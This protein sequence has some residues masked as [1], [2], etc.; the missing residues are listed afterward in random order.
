M[1]YRDPNEALRAENESLQQQIKDA[2]EELDG[3]RARVGASAEGDGERQRLAL[4]M[5]CLGGV[6]LML[7]FLL[8]TAMCEHRF[9]PRYHHAPASMAVRYDA[10]PS[11]ASAVNVP[12]P[13]VAH[14]CQGRTAPSP[15]FE[16]FTRSIE[17]SARVTQADNLP[18]I[19]A[20]TPC[21]VRVVPVSM[22][23]FNCHVEVVCNGETL[24]G[25]LPTGYAHCDVDRATLLHATDS[26]VTVADGDPAVNV[27]LTSYRAVVT[28][29]RDGVTTRALLALDAPPSLD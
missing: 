13:Y 26:D 21:T 3:L 17:R 14:G 12:R 22:Q 8:M 18:G 9:T 19:T 28:D 15:G 7:P 27:D 25:A 2:N 6:A 5:R 1:S 29:T 10:A 23:D 20:G 4:G 24:Y 16:G 11:V